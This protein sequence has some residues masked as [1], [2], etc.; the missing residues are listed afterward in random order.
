EQLRAQRLQAR[1]FILELALHSISELRTELGGNLEKLIQENFML[2]ES[3]WQA[4]LEYDQ[5]DFGSFLQSIGV[6]PLTAT[7]QIIPK[8][9]PRNWLISVSDSRLTDPYAAMLDIAYGERH[10]SV[11]L[12]CSE[13]GQSVIMTSRPGV[14]WDGMSESVNRA[15]IEFL[16]SYLNNQ[17]SVLT[18][19]GAINQR[20]KELLLGPVYRERELDDAYPELEAEVINGEV[21]V[22]DKRMTVYRLYSREE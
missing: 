9:D 4:L 8:S 3:I 7:M 10:T 2:Q 5:G 18:P 13:D 1:N 11:G 6:E 19:E 21:S 12:V 15:T 16:K 14:E 17:V 20:Q 22:S